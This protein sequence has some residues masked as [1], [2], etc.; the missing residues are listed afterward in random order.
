MKARVTGK[1]SQ[2]FKRLPVDVAD[3][4]TFRVLTCLVNKCR[5]N[6]KAVKVG[7]R[8]V[9]VRNGDGER[10]PLEDWCESCFVYDY[11]HRCKDAGML[12][13]IERAR[14]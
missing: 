3:E 8:V 4:V 5:T 12:K 6:T 2:A 11:N 14:L 13:A 9:V 10:R 7:G 1:T